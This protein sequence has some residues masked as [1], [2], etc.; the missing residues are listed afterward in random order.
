MP[1]DETTPPDPV[2]SPAPEIPLSGGISDSSPT[3]D[4]PS[5]DLP[6]EAPETPPND[7][8]VP[9]VKDQNQASEPSQSNMQEPENQPE[10]PVAEAA[11]PTSSFLQNLLQKANAVLR[12]RK[13]QKLDRIMTLF[14]KRAKITNDEVEKFLH[15]SDATATRY[16]S[17][18][19][20]EGKIVQAGKTG[21]SVFYTKPS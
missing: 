19:E 12:T 3:T 1:P 5:A 16:L 20:R 17:I 6:P 11:I 21:H 18:L 2:T 10:I 14:E 15:V 7:A 13:Q 9:L 8:V 4:S